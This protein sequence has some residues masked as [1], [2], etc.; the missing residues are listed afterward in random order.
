MCYKE[1]KVEE[2]GE[3]TRPWSNIRLTF[4]N[5][6][7]RYNETNFELHRQLSE[8]FKKLRRN[9]QIFNLKLLFYECESKL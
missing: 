9:F 5:V 3:K 1:L 8:G 2:T 6:Q 7:R 4:D